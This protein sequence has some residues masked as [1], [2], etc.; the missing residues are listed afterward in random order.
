MAVRPFVKGKLIE[1]Y[2]VDN[3]KIQVYDGSLV[4]HSRDDPN[5][6][7]ILERIGQIATRAELRQEESK[8]NL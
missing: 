2:V 6:L 5:V 4:S 8:G 7:K 3:T 1:E